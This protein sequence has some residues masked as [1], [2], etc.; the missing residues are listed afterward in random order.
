[1]IRAFVIDFSKAGQ[2]ASM[3]AKC[4]C[5]VEIEEDDG[6]RAYKAV[7]ETKPDLIFV[8]YGHKPS[9]GRQTAISI[10]RRRSTAHIPV[11]FVDGES[12]EI[13]RLEGLGETIRLDEIESVVNKQ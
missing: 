9:H 4:G 3:L 11:Y 5:Q 2:I 1:M 7:G 8:N 10:R 6:A 12:D 13:R